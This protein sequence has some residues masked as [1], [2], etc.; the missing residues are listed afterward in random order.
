MTT[1]R[2]MAQMAAMQE[3]VIAA[4]RGGGDGYVADRL[5]R[6][7]RARLGRRQHGG[8]PWTCRSSGCLWCGK[9]LMRRWWVGIEHWATQDGTPVSLAVLPL[10]R[11]AGQLRATVARLR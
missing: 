9:T 7:M 5:G 6:C 2:Q 11:D 4:L 8:R 1:R 3:R 10:P